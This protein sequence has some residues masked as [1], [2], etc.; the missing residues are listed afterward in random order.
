MGYD[1]YISRNIDVMMMWYAIFFFFLKVSFF[2]EQ[3]SDIDSSV[4]SHIKS[5][6]VMSEN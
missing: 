4:S 5:N 6:L 2:Q 3:K 1:L